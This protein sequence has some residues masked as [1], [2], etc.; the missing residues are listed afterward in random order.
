MCRVLE[1]YRLEGPA[2]AKEALVCLLASGS[3]LG[4]ERHAIESHNAREK[5]CASELVKLVMRHGGEGGGADMNDSVFT[6]RDTEVLYAPITQADIDAFRAQERLIAL[7]ANFAIAPDTSGCGQLFPGDEPNLPCADRT[8]MCTDFFRSVSNELFKFVVPNHHK[9]TEGTLTSAIQSVRS[10]VGPARDRTLQALAAWKD[11]ED[12]SDVAPNTPEFTISARLENAVVL[13]R[14]TAAVWM[15]GIVAKRD[16]SEA[17]LHDR[18]R[19][20]RATP[21]KKKAKKAGTEQKPQKG[22]QPLSRSICARAQQVDMTMHHQLHQTAGQ[23]MGQ[24]VGH[25]LAQHN[26]ELWGC[27]L[28]V[29]TQRQATRGLPAQILVVENQGRY[30][31]RVPRD[32]AGWM[33]LAAVPLFAS[34]PHQ[35]GTFSA[36]YDVPGIT[37]S[38]ADADRDMVDEWVEDLQDVFKG[39]ICVQ[40]MAAVGFQQTE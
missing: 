32:N 35:R 39:D 15:G 2:A 36:L 7:D 31:A 28:H 22:K 20:D 23:A 37:S 10:L 13:M 5:T 34:P 4:S 11:V 6:L 1:A 21:S 29:G 3:A 33:A 26:V 8:R 18:E 24:T 9:Q 12:A 27:T 19:G 14:A 17:Q 38:E 30:I 25:D 16:A 40:A